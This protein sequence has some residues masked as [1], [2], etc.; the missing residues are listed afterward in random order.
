MSLE[1]YIELKRIFFQ[2]SISSDIEGI[3][4]WDMSTMMPNNARYQ[5]ADQLAFMAKLKHKL[6]SDVRVGNLIKKIESNT[7]NKKDQANFYEM[8]REYLLIS[9]LPSDLVE[10]LSKASAECEGYWQEARKKSDFSIVKKSLKN[11]IN[12]T[13]EEATI[14]GEKLKCSPYEALIKKYE[15]LADIDQITGVFNDLK[16]FLISS[17]DTIIEKQKSDIYLPILEN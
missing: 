2:A 6:I 10:S 7:L 8:K 13:K 15:P 17:M 16:F 5:R 14:T 1:A 11:L 4:H 12:L 9:A 3:L